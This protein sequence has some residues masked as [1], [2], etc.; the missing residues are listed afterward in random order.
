LTLARHLTILLFASATFAALCQEATPPPEPIV[1]KPAPA[2]TDTTTPH[3]TESHPVPTVAPK[4]KPT[5][6][7]AAAL[8]QLQSGPFNRTVIVLDPAHGGGDSGSRMNDQLVEKDV[9]LALA[10]RLR[11]LLSARGFTVIMTREDDAASSAP[12]TPLSFD[13]RA[14]IANHARPLACLLLH[15][16]ASGTG[17]HVYTSELSPAPGETVPTPWLTAQAPWVTQSQALAKQVGTAFGR[18]KVPAVVSRA[19]VRPLDS[20]TCPALVLELAPSTTDAATLSDGS[21]QQRVAE[22]LA[23]SLVVWKNQAQPPTRILPPPSPPSAP[24][25]EVKP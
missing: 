8:A 17:V 23:D 15:A 7:P 22:A 12:G 1:R 10:F 6:S 16:T 20:L 24:P 11:S 3:L 9:T 5:I 13:D 18:A 25:P 4:P 21:Y 2:Q 14:G 19:S